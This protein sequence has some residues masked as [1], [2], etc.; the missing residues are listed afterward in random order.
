LKKHILFLFGTRPEII[1]LAPVIKEFKRFPDRYKIYITNT[2]QH[3]DMSDQT[4][5]FFSLQTDFDLDVMTTNQTLGSLCGNLF[6]KLEEVFQKFKFDGVFAQGDTASVFVASQ[7][8]FF[9]KVPFFHIEAGLRSGDLLHP[10]PEEMIRRSVSNVTTLHFSPTEKAKNNLLDEKYDED[11]IFVTGNTVIDS[12]LIILSN[13]ELCSKEN[14]IVLVTIHRRENHGERLLDI[15]DA[16]SELANKHKS[17]EFILPVHPNPQVKSI[18]FDRLG[19]KENIILKQPLDY[20]E[21]VK[22]LKIAKLVLTDSGGIQEEAPTFQTPILVLRDKTERTEGVDAGFA[23]LVGARKHDIIQEADKILYQSFEKSRVKA[24]NPFGDGK[25][26]KRIQ[27]IVSNYFNSSL[28]QVV[29]REMPVL[30]R[31]QRL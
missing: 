23:K 21:L 20:L 27:K 16:I 6:L 7:L 17:V 3:R 1:K 15:L 2:A 26:S 8:S 28:K 30:P 5:K 22:I 31:R 18:I 19:K 4:L 25:A 14:E 11:S 24:K 29:A 13:L 12:L 10:F 9:F